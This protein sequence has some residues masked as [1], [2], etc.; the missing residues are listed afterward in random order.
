MAWGRWIKVDGEDILDMSMPWM[1]YAVFDE[2]HSRIVS[3]K[4]DTPAEI[5]ELYNEYKRIEEKNKSANGLIS[6]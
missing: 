5:V 1:D 6:R 2:N 3:L 4:E